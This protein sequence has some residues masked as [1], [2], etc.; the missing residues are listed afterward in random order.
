M[1]M[2]NLSQ[3]EQESLKQARWLRSMVNSQGFRKV[4]QPWLEDKIKHSWL[5]PREAKD[6]GDFKRRYEI[7][8]ALAQSADQ[9]LKFFSNAVAEAEALEKKEKGEEE[10]NFAIGE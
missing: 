9:I 8:W 10:D 6:D 1:Q 5:D 7:A 2:D 4:F 3:Q